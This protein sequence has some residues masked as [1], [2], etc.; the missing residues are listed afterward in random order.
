[1][2]QKRSILDD[3]SIASPCPLKFEQMTGDEKIRFCDLCQLNVY[4]VS[5][6]TRI[7]AEELLNDKSD[8]VCLRLYR[9]KDGTLITKDCPVGKRFSDRIKF[10][11]RSIAAVIVSFIGSASALAQAD[12]KLLKEIGRTEGPTDMNL[13]EVSNVI[14]GRPYLKRDKDGSPIKT[15]SRPY[16]DKGPDTSAKDAFDAAIKYEADKNY[17]SALASY[18][19]SIDAFRNSKNG[20][21]AVFA[22]MVAKRYAT[23]LRLTK[24]KKKAKAI[25]REFSREKNK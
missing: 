16:I 17:E 6:M 1:M 22:K 23:L 9:R 18:E 20:Y 13:F 25:E 21:D 11:I 24:N 8:Q 10:K 14:D 15:I 4:N 7:E 5:Q 12:S 3:V 19:C 2:F